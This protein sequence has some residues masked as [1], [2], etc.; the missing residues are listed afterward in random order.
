MTQLVKVFAA[1]PNDLRLMPK[2][3]VVEWRELTSTHKQ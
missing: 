3:H 1:G 2:T